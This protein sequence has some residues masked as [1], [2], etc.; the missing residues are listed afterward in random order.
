MRVGVVMEAFA[1]WPLADALDWL[2][3]NAPEATDLELIAGGY[4]PTGHC[5]REALLEAARTTATFRISRGRVAARP[6]ARDRVAVGRR[7]AGVLVGAGELRS[8]VHADLLICLELH[9]GT[10]VNNVE[11]FERLGEV[12]SNI[13][14]KIDPSHFFWQQMD[15]F[16]IIER[17]GPRIGHAHAKDVTFNAAKLALNG[18]LDRRWQ[19]PPEEMP[20]TSPPWERATTRAGG[21]S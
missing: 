13:A 7:G 9:P 16:A 14:A 18:L 2:S 21:T 15:A 10:V 17:L 12:G 4:G 3:A 11:T 8:C 1:D 6:G 19:A 5:D 20:W